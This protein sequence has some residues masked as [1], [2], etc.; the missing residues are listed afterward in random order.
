[1]ITPINMNG[2]A[3]IIILMK[4]VFKFKNE[5]GN[6]LLAEPLIGSTNDIK[7]ITS[8]ISIIPEKSINVLRNNFIPL[9]PIPTFP[10]FFLK[11]ALLYAVVDFR[12]RTLASAGRAV[13][14][15]GA[16]A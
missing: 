9:P 14:L 4:I 8:P 10:D 11:K 16:N 5:L 1:M 3:S 6:I 12:Y 13:S 7:A 15:L 2:K